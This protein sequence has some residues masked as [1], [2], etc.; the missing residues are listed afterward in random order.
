MVRP[1]ENILHLVEKAAI[2]KQNSKSEWAINY[3]TVVLNRLK[4][5]YPSNGK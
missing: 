1:E 5:R 2:A 3:W 4:V